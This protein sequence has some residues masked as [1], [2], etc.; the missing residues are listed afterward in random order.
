MPYFYLQFAIDAAFKMKRSAL[1]SY[2]ICCTVGLRHE[3]TQ[4]E[5]QVAVAR[6]QIPQR[7]QFEGPSLVCRT[8]NRN[9]EFW[10]VCAMDGEMIERA[11]ATH[12]PAKLAGQMSVAS[13]FRDHALMFFRRAKL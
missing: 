5:P 7:S 12:A 6:S 13:S 10:S 4:S 1:M 11:W 8:N 2:D 3:P 9:T